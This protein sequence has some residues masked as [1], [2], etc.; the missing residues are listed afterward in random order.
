VSEEAKELSDEAWEAVLSLIAER[1]SAMAWQAGVGGMETAGALVSYLVRFPRDIRP[2]I[3]GG[4]F[5]LADDW[6]LRGS[7]TWTGKGGKVHKPDDV[8]LRKIVNK[9]KP[10]NQRENSNG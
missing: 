1:A 9:M 10:T 4:I 5:E 7:L 2:F 8:R 6:F 3:N